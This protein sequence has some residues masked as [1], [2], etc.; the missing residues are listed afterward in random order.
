MAKQYAPCPNC[1]ESNAEKMGFTWWGGALGPSLFT[2]VKCQNCKAQY[3]GKSGNYN[4][5]AITIYLVVSIVL[6]LILGYVLV[7]QLMM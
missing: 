2:H 5:T 1:G 7:T 4:T 6:G 3:N